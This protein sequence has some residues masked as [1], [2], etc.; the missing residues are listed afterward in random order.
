MTRHQTD[1]NDTYDIYLHEKS[2]L[3]RNFS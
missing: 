3:S 1:S 2:S